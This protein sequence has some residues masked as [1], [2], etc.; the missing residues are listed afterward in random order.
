MDRFAIMVDAGYLYASAGE[1]CFG[2]SKRGDLSL[3]PERVSLALAEICR[4]HSDL[5]HLRTYWYDGAPDAVP[6]QEQLAIA[7]QKGVKLRLGRL[8]RHQGQKGVDSR[9]VRDLIILPRNRGVRSI[10][11]MSG[12]E[13][14]REGVVEAQELG[15]SV[16]LMGIEPPKGQF[17]QAATLVREADDIIVLA[18]S[19]CERFLERAVDHPEVKKE[20]DVIVEDDSSPREFGNAYGQAT[21][22][23]LDSGTL[24]TV[25]E[26]H[27]RIPQ[28]IDSG[29]LKAA[30]ASLGNDKI[31][32]QEARRELR[33]GFWDGF[34]Q[35]IADPDE[36]VDDGADEIEEDRFPP[37]EELGG[38]G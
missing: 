15:V 32:T 17:N 18:R 16:I 8:T 38:E 14:V 11:L 31:D 4:K 25:M 24:S 23:E 27:P 19:D 28:T 29:L 30:G 12:D 20:L 7:T 10:Y 9:I 36:S 1:L 35:A 13:D 2:T 34:Q 5:Q 33:A 6:S 3:D 21:R 22:R 26:I 37:A